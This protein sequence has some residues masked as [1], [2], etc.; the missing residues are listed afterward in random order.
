MAAVV[1]IALVWTENVSDL[2]LTFAILGVN[3]ILYV[4]VGLLIGL[5]LS[6]ERE[7]S[8]ALVFLVEIVVILATSLLLTNQLVGEVFPL[9]H[10]YQLLQTAVV[11]GGL[12]SGH[13][14]P[15]VGYTL[16]AEIVAITINRRT[17]S[18]NAYLVSLY[19]HAALDTPVPVV[20]P[21][22]GQ[23][24]AL[25]ADVLTGLGVVLVAAMVSDSSDSSSSSQ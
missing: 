7:G 25:L 11:D 2:I 20:I 13:V 15:V 8:L 24:M 18:V 1:T 6:G 9:Y 5:I 10:P 4:F 22:G 16:A 12:S 19:G 21:N 17:A 3:G 14:L 23:T